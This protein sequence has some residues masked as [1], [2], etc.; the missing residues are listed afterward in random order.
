[1]EIQK[2]ELATIQK[3]SLFLLSEP[4]VFARR[5]LYFMIGI[6]HFYTSDQYGESRQANAYD[7]FLLLYIMKGRLEI[8][9][10]N[11][12]SLVG[13][14]QIALLD[15]YEKHSYRSLVPT[16]F[17]Y[18][19]FDGNNSRAFYEEIVRTEGSVFTDPCFSAHRDA[20]LTLCTDIDSGKMPGEGEISVLI[21][22]ILCELCN[23]SVAEYSFKYSAYVRKALSFIESNFTA[24]ISVANIAGVCNLS[25][26]H[27]NRLFRSETG[28][29][30]YQYILEKRMR[31]ACTVLLHSDCS[32][33]E[34]A[35]KAGFANPFNFMNAF[36]KKYGIT[37]GRY[38]KEHVR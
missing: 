38:R 13:D 25:P 8:Q 9:T 34:T 2:K 30:P 37:P 20:L 29:S 6:G 3:N 24:E 22:R 11:G 23:K 26:Q 21:H 1:M 5:F 15:C 17:V 33:E 19:H 32:V 28:V 14:G 12:T 18:I 35:Y 4:S 27:L 31:Y 7:S 36:K 10:Q 16:E